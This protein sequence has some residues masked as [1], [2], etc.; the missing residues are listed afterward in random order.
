[1][2]FAISPEGV[3]EPP[4]S[5]DLVA[6]TPREDGRVLR[7]FVCRDCLGLVEV[8]EGEE[9]RHECAGVTAS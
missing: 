7:H 4:D 6:E 5:A 9:H 2:D 1:M 3:P 8:A